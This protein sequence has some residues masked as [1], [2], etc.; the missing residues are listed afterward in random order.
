MVVLV[1]SGFAIAQQVD[2]INKDIA[3]SIYLDLA[4]TLIVGEVSVN[5]ELPLQSHWLLRFGI[6]MGYYIGWETDASKTSA[7]LLSMINFIPGGSSSH[8]ECGAGLSLNRIVDEYDSVYIKIYPA[9]DIGYRYQSYEGGFIFRTGLGF[10]F[11][12]G[13]LLYLS[14]GTTI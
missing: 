9:F 6:G 3:Q 8:F 13:Y 14:F 12:F 10:T 5:Y 7:G 1:N 11:A 2:S 4:T